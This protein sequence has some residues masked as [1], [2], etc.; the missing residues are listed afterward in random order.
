VSIAESGDDLPQ[1]RTRTVAG[2]CGSGKATMGT[3]LGILTGAAGMLAFTLH[4]AN[5]SRRH[6]QA[7]IDASVASSRVF[8]SAQIPPNHLHPWLGPALLITDHKARAGDDDARASGIY[9]R[10]S[11]EKGGRV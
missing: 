4:R 3:S 5:A 11:R 9:V 8:G 10:L 7:I 1:W 6:R 2:R